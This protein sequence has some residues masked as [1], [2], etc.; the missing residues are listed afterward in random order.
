[1]KS[2]VLDT[3]IVT[4]WWLD[5]KSMDDQSHLYIWIL[6]VFTVN[7]PKLFLIVI[8]AYKAQ[9]VV[10]ERG[11]LLT[12]N[13]PYVHIPVEAFKWTR[14]T[15]LV[16][17]SFPFGALHGVKLISKY[18]RGDIIQES[19]SKSIFPISWHLQKWLFVSRVI[20]QW[21]CASSLQTTKLYF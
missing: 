19:A 18:Y 9:C 8:K 16:R 11:T 12:D 17:Y 14:T 3:E 2:R 20:P 10:S 6:F 1:M 7:K 21:I 5:E 13:S 4:R 15:S